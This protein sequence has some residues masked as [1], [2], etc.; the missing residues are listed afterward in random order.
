MNP[1]PSLYSKRTVKFFFESLDSLKNQS[2]GQRWNGICE[3]AVDLFY[4]VYPSGLGE[5]PFQRNQLWS[6]FFEP[7][8]VDDETYARFL[9]LSQTILFTNFLF[10]ILQ[11]F[12]DPPS[13]WWSSHYI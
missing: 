12:L 2:G 10:T 4:K 6:S 11:A 8:R 5:C 7:L 13:S 9:T 1:E 3:D